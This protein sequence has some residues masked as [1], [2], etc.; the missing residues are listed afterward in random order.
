MSIT[1]DMALSG[2]PTVLLD[3]RV[4][5]RSRFAECTSREQLITEF[6]KAFGTITA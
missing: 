1:R 5:D 4:R 6:E 2:T 3:M